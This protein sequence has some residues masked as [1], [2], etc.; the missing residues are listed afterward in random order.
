[1]LPEQ[2]NLV[3]SRR[4]IQEDGWTQEECLQH[5]GVL[6]CV[7]IVSAFLCLPLII[8]PFMIY[9]TYQIEIAVI[10]G[11]LGVLSLITAIFSFAWGAS[12]QKSQEKG[13]L[14]RVGG[15]LF[16]F[17]TAILVFYFLSFIVANLSLDIYLNEML[18]KKSDLTQF[19]LDIVMTTWVLLG[20]FALLLICFGYMAFSLYIC[21]VNETFNRVLLNV[22]LVLFL[23]FNL[24]LIYL[25]TQVS[26]LMETRSLQKYVE[27]WY[28]TSSL[29]I[30]IIG[31]I[32]SLV[33]LFVNLRR[34][35]VIYFVIGST[36][37]IFIVISL[38][39]AGLTHRRADSL[40]QNYQ[41]NC[42]TDMKSTDQGDLIAQGCPAKYLTKTV[43][44]TLLY[45]LNCNVSERALIWETDQTKNIS[46]KI[47]AMACLNTNCCNLLGNIY[48]LWFY[49]LAYCYLTMGVFGFICVCCLFYLSIKVSL[50]KNTQVHW[51]YFFC[52]VML[53]MLIALALMTQLYDAESLG[54]EQY[55]VTSVVSSKYDLQFQANLQAKVY[56][57]KGQTC[58]LFYTLIENKTEY[59]DLV[60]VNCSDAACRNKTAVVRLAL[61]GNGNF[62]VGNGANSEQIKFFNSTYRNTFFPNNSN[63]SYDFLLFEG[64]SSD[65]DAFLQ[66]DLSFCL[67]DYN[68]SV[69]FYYVKYVYYP[70]E[71]DTSSLTTQTMIQSTRT[72]KKQ[73]NAQ[74]SHKDTTP[75]YFL[76]S[77]DAESL[78]NNY[79]FG[80]PKVIVVDSDSA[81]ALPNVELTFYRSNENSSC[82][83]NQATA[84]RRGNT[85]SNGEATFY[86]LV[87]QDF[88]VFAKAT[89]YKGNCQKVT[90]T[91]VFD[92]ANIY[93]VL[94]P[95]FSDQALRIFLF[96]NNPL[97]SLSLQSSF[98]YN[99]EELCVS[100]YFQDQC[101]NM[102]F[103]QRKSVG[104]LS[105]QSIDISQIGEYNYLIYTQKLQIGENLIYYELEQNGN[106]TT[107]STINNQDFID[108]EPFIQIYS[109][110]M[111]YPVDSLVPPQLGSGDLTEPDLVW[112]G[113][114]VNGTVGEVGKR[115][116]QQFWTKVQ[117]NAT[118][119]NR[120]VGYRN[121]LPDASICNG[122]Y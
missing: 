122:V 120:L 29:I 85:D 92:S 102:V 5:C 58:D 33:C 52:F 59:G 43:N 8:V 88:L 112:L 93:L 32:L 87:A 78:L 80:N 36:L 55:L 6:K 113:F 48:S 27:P 18:A 117:A 41:D 75:T 72:H 54:A 118:Y 23:F 10:F 116:V 77:T 26:K 1:M 37:L 83:N 96:W 84:F 4:E 11:V 38:L 98:N 100:G 16:V 66:K 7:S 74:K 115:N 21:S 61:E 81:Q 62:T 42:L 97:V 64:T 12:Y 56:N 67:S 2:S 109:K 114:C 104:T 86:N 82:Q 95:E 45:D 44:D 25:S 63:T 65:V 71:V 24:S 73:K 30:G 40:Q 57:S 3:D 119:Y 110:G 121:M 101:G 46:D 53:F 70:G 9:N 90:N 22:Y 47:D 28:T 107:N 49:G 31:A 108:S 68:V 17:V 34:Y 94:I 39:F 50:G 76:L 105:F 15:V 99:D 106:Q 35:R 111:E 13:E 19:N 89:N 91:S 51:D 69:L 79:T 103:G 60:S 20:F 14:S